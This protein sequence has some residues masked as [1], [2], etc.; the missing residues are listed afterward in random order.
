MFKIFHSAPL[1]STA[2]F[3]AKCPDFRY[4]L[5]L[6]VYLVSKR[7]HVMI[8]DWVH[9]V[10]Q[11]YP[12]TFCIEAQS[13]LDYNNEQYSETQSDHNN[14]ING[15]QQCTKTHTNTYIHCI[16]FHF[17]NFVICSY[18]ISSFFFS[19]CNIFIAFLLVSTFYFFQSHP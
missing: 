2:I 15:T 6:F 4:Q 10:G 18:L 8:C 3:Y 19:F 12:Q 7:R 9:W 13:I 16:S 14:T 5:V 17:G 1:L 11:F